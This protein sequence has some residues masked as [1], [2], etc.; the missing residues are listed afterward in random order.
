MKMNGQ[1]GVESRDCKLG[2]Y[3]LLIGTIN[4]NV[5]KI[6]RVCVC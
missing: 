4:G 5:D 2:I 1:E 3:S 6:K